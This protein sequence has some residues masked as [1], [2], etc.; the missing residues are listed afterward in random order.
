MIDIPIRA[1]ETSTFFVA[2]DRMPTGFFEALRDNDVTGDDV[3]LVGGF[4]ARLVALNG[5]DFSQIERVDLRACPV[6]TPNGCTDITFNLFSITDNFNRRQQTLNLNP[7][8]VN[9][10][11]LF[12]GSDE[13]RFEIVVFPGQTTSFPIEARLEWEIQAVGDLD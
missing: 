12:V 7:S 4:R 5:E 2:R 11:N 13:F 9:L 1:G 6:G 8:P 10:R 3:D